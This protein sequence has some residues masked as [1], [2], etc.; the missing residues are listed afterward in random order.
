MDLETTV[1]DIETPELDAEL[2]KRAE[3]L[4]TQMDSGKASERVLLRVMEGYVLFSEVLAE[5]IRPVDIA[6]QYRRLGLGASTAYRAI[7]SGLFRIS[8]DGRGHKYMSHAHHLTAAHALKALQY[9]DENIIGG[10]I[11]AV[12]VYAQQPGGLITESLLEIEG[13]VLSALSQP[14]RLEKIALSTRHKLLREIKGPG[15][16]SPTTPED[17][18]REVAG[19]LAKE[20]G[21]KLR[22]SPWQ[23]KAGHVLTAPVFSGPEFYGNLALGI[24]PLRGLIGS[25]AYVGRYPGQSQGEPEPV[26]LRHEGSF[27]SPDAIIL[28]ANRPYM[29]T[30]AR[31]IFVFTALGRCD[32]RQMP[33]LGISANPDNPQC[34]PRFTSPAFKAAK[35]AYI[36][37]EAK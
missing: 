29:E 13:A 30:Y 31:N 9:A 4:F 2:A 37:V 23:L 7:L 17:A 5:G 22:V 1:V 11:A 28:E 24:D 8:H 14:D 19:Q 15:K 10:L 34:Y 6:A 36:T 3:N 18:L 32:S 35:E 20:M 21:S 33:F 26:M 27:P 25:V 12:A 16:Y